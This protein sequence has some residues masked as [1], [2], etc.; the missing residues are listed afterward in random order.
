MLTCYCRELKMKTLNVI[1]IFLLVAGS[2]AIAAEVK[3]P[4]V[5][6]QKGLYAEGPFLLLAKR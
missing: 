6:L 4:A 2:L 5:L 1:L 3:S